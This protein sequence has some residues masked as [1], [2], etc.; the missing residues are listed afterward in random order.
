M[1]SPKILQLYELG[2]KVIL[3]LWMALIVIA[4]WSDQ[5]P[6]YWDW[7]QGKVPYGILWVWLNPLYWTNLPYEAYIVGVIA[8][9]TY[10]NWYLVKKG[11]LGKVPFYMGWITSVIWMRASTFQNVT[12]TAFAPAAAVWPIL[13]LLLVLQKLPVGWSWP[14]QNNAHWDCAFNG[15]QPYSDVGSP[16]GLQCSSA[17]VRWN[18]GLPYVYS[19]GILGFWVIYPLVCWVLKKRR[20]AVR[21]EYLR[22]FLG[23]PN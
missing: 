9:Q 1:L 18:F 4:P 21:N 10:V 11:K 12:V 23:M 16:H 19:Y 13:T 7:V 2:L 5:L 17:A 3:P 22:A 20:V 15:T 8:L 6:L 14:L